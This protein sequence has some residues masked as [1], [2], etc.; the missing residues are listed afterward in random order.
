MDIFM[1]AIAILMAM[2]YIYIPCV[3]LYGIASVLEEESID[4]V[5]RNPFFGIKKTS[6]KTGFIAWVLQC[7]FLGVIVSEFYLYRFHGMHPFFL[8][9]LHL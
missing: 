4:E 8:D 6:V 1:F 2:V 3:C 9:Y 5:I 7:L